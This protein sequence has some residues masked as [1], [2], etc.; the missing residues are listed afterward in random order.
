MGFVSSFQEKLAK[1]QAVKNESI[2]GLEAAIEQEKK[3]QWRVEGRSYLFD[4]KRVRSSSPTAH[5]LCSLC[6][7]TGVP[8]NSLPSNEPFALGVLQTGPIPLPY[9]ATFAIECILLFY[10]LARC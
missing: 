6:C 10:V 2:E 4:A 7:I 8:L 3:E 9:P 1:A 5:F